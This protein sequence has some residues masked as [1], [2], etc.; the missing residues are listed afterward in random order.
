[1]E[2][3]KTKNE[4]VKWTPKVRIWYWDVGNAENYVIVD[5]DKRDTIENLLNN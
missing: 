1:M 4:I 3:A 2:T 5:E